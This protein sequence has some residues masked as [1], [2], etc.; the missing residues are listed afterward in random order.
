[1]SLYNNSNQ[2]AYVWNNAGNTFTWQSGLV[3]PENEWCMIAAS[4]NPTSA[5]AYLYQLSG[6]SSATNTVSHSPTTLDAIEIGRDQA[7][8]SR[9]FDGK[10]S[11]AQVYDRA[12]T[13]A[14]ITQNYEITKDRY[15]Y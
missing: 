7:V 12:L 4:V 15:G 14:E 13:Q 5:T 10:I 9:I 11:V 6:I 3:V 8:S 2:V 1:M